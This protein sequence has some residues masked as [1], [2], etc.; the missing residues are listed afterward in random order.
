M[1][2]HDWY[3]PQHSSDIWAL[4]L[5]MLEVVGGVIPDDQWDLQNSH[6]YLRELEE[7][8]ISVLTQQ[9]AYRK[10]LQYLSNLITK[11]GQRDYA[12]Q[13]GV[14]YLLCALSAVA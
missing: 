6:E 1:L 12:D 11:P 14:L 10:H 13:V 5:L 7:E 8:G 9:P 2:E 3:H 4:G